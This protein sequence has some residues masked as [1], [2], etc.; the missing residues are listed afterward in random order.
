MAQDLDA[1]LERLRDNAGAVNLDRIEADVRARIAGE[2]R[3]SAPEMVWGWR[4]AAAAL[5]LAI[6]AL[7]SAGTRPAAAH[8]I[9][10]TDAYLAP[11]TLL[12]GRE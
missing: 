3:W 7:A 5:V 11:S 2:R 10:S 1:L 9:F 8:A 6:G 4:A 12:E